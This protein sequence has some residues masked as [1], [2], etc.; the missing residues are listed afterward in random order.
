[1][2]NIVLFFSL[3]FLPNAYS[4]DA[5][6]I[7]LN[8]PLLKEASLHS[9]VLQT[10]RT[11]DHLYVP[12][13]VGNLENLPE[14]IQTYDRVGNTAYIPS[15]YIKI[16]TNDLS[17]NKMPISY[18]G[19]DPTDYRLEEPIPA[20]YPFEDNSFVRSSF[21]IFS[22]NNMKSSYDYNSTLNTQ[23]FSSET[24]GRFSLSRKVEFDKYDRYYFGFLAAISFSN[25]TIQFKNNNE[26]IEDRS[27]LR[28][29]PIITFDAF[30]N[31][32]Y[33]LTLGTGF[34]YNFHKSTLKMS[35][36]SG[37]DQRVFTGYSLSPIVSTLV[38]IID[39]FPR[40][41]IIAGVDLSLFLPH[42]QKTKDAI[43]VPDLW[44]SETPGQIHAGIAPQVSFFLGLQT[45]Y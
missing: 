17:E 6:V 29:G 22:G 35:G 43:T 28:L 24:G 25:N 15:K 34:T 5:V 31:S 44:A 40:T 18:P 11:G 42:T 41:D 14:F 45:K 33:R 37:S 26:A 9:L 4:Y 27:L 38:Q 7:V 21:A 30:K 12:T 20:T 1:M 2:K 10:L 39:V 8:A 3:L 19:S 23:S 32:D 36:A 13:E 16:I